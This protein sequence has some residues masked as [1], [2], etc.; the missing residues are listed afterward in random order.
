MA[1]RVIFLFLQSFMIDITCLGHACYLVKLGT[2]S[3]VF[4]PFIRPNPLAAQIDFKA[5][6]ADYILISHGHEDHIADAVALAQQTNAKLIS[7]WE[8]CHWLEKQ[9]LSQTI[10]MN[11][12]GKWRHPEFSVK[13]VSA[14]HSSSLPDG[15]YGGNPMGFIIES[16]LGNFYFAGDTALNYDMKL[17]GDYRRIQFAFL[18]IGDHFTMG[19]DNALI[20]TDFIQCDTIIGMHY[21]TFKPIEIDSDAAVKKFKSAGRTLHLIPIGS[22]IQL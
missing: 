22:S 15:T 17:I 7:N 21:N 20:A 1:Q 8:I 4:D 19:V 3:L 11:I 16:P 14:V 5:L 6:H 13:C 18:P 2:V 12:G 9:G 10:P